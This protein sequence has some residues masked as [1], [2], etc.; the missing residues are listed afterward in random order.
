M[1][2]TRFIKQIDQFA[3]LVCYGGT[4]TVLALGLSLWAGTL[5]WPRSRP[6]MI[7]AVAMGVLSC[8]GQLF[9]IMALQMENAGLVSLVRSCDVSEKRL[10]HI[11]SFIITILSLP[12]L[13]IHSSV[14]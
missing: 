14:R 5:E 10:N 2:I 6:D 8:V 11:S 4:G 9:M 1:I 13:L 3:I 12:L 7:L